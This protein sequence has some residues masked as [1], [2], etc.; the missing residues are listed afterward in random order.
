LAAGV[1]AAAELIKAQM[2]QYPIHGNFAFMDLKGSLNFIEVAG[3]KKSGNCF[4]Y[5]QSPAIYLN[6]LS[7]SRWGQAL[8]TVASIAVRN[9]KGFFFSASFL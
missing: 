7:K 1:L 9:D 3:R 2:D 5:R 6:T 8:A 4:C